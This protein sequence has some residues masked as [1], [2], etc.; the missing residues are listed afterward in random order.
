MIRW[1]VL[2]SVQR[3]L[4]AVLVIVVLAVVSLTAHAYWTWQRYVESLD[5]SAVPGSPSTPKAPPTAVPV[6]GLFPRRNRA[7]QEPLRIGIVAGHWESDAG[8]VCPDGLREVDINLAVAERVVSILNR[9]GYEA[10][11]LPEFSEKLNGYRAAALVS[12]HTDSCTVPEATGFKVA[13]VT[14]S[15]VPDVDDRLVACLVE[16]Y[17]R[18][19]GLAVHGSSITFDMTEYHAFFEIA[20][21]TPAAIIETGFMAA[22]RGLL[23]RRPHVVARGIVEGIVCF[24]EPKG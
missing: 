16:H 4:L 12:I 19:T 7:L 3:V 14:S 17:G 21:E 2:E 1:G 5:A 9:R 20:P 13:R 18:E 10:E 22:D 11:I 6:G 24:L 23:T 15:Y 8:A